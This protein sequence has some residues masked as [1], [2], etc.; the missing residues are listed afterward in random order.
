MRGM[1]SGVLDKQCIVFVVVIS[2]VCDNQSNIPGYSSEVDKLR[3]SITANEKEVKEL[4][5]SL[6]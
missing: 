4:L 5:D 1:R 6:M 2:T 3:E